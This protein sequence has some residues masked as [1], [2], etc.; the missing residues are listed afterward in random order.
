M[1]SIL[2]CA[3]RV[4][5][6]VACTFFH[7]PVHASIL[8]TD[9]QRAREEL[10]IRLLKTDQVQQQLKRVEVAEWR[11]PGYRFRG[12]PRPGNVIQKKGRKCYHTG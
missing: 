8:G 3:M 6:L 12:L 1:K 11:Q 2:R 7:D 9:Q 10:A 4:S 5:L